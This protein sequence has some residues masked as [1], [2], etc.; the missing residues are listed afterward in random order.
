MG[1]TGRQASS[2]EAIKTRPG[3][4]PTSLTVS[5]LRSSRA[6]NASRRLGTLSFSSHPFFQ[7]FLYAL[8]CFPSSSALD[9]FPH[10]F[11]LAIRESPLAAIHDESHLNEL[12]QR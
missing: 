11:P 4:V 6:R 9:G 10:N 1:Q 3:N 5:S 2:E 7:I 8:C 12:G